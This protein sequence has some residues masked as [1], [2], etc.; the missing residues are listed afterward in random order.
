MQSDADRAVVGEVVVPA[1]LDEVWR[2]WTTKEGAEAFF[3]PRCDIDP[4]PGG[5]YEILFDLEAAPGEQGSEGMMVMAVEPPRMLAF[6]WNAPPQLAGVRGQM[7]HVV[8][9]LERIT[10]RETRVRLRHDGWGE[11]GEWDA[12][13]AYFDRAWNRVVLPRLVHRFAVGPVAW[14]QPPELRPH[15]E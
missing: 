4:R 10:D 12:A 8:L 9:R 1:S 13:F 5:R 2:A 14:E 7:T 6:S 15:A 3:A 11:G